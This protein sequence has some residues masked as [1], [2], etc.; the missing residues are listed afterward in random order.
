M[1]IL[2]IDGKCRNRDLLLACCQILIEENTGDPGEITRLVEFIRQVAVSE[3]CLPDVAAL[4]VLA[5]MN[6][7][8]HNTMAEREVGHA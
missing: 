7:D 4:K 3:Q 1:A 6:D 2:V 8:L 5:A